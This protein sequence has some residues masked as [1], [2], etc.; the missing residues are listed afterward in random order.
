MA[1]GPAIRGMAN[2]GHDSSTAR[3]M[4][5]GIDG[6]AS[7]PRQTRNELAAIGSFWYKLADFLSVPIDR[8][9]SANGGHGWLVLGKNRRHSICSA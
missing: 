1:E 8:G 3:G 6:I 7:T 5:L 9:E 2:R 4:R